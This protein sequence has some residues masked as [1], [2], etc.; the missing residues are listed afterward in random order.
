MQEAVSSE[1]WTVPE[2]HKADAAISQN[3]FGSF[4]RTVADSPF[5][6]PGTGNQET[7]VSAQA[8]SVH[9]T[10]HSTRAQVAEGFAQSFMSPATATGASEA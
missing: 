8:G 4:F 1:M 7:A 9:D 6:K 2:T 10:A 3:P 5:R